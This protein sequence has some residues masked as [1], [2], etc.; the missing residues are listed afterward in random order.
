MKRE[1]KIVRCDCC[2]KRMSESEHAIITIRRPGCNYSDLYDICKDC[3]NFFESEMKYKE[4]VKEFF[5][6]LSE[7]ELIKE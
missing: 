4:R 5:C 2:G 7:E 3:V 6:D 1:I